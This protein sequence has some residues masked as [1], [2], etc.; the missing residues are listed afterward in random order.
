M[1][2]LYSSSIHFYK[3]PSWYFLEIECPFHSADD[4]LEFVYDIGSEHYSIIIPLQR[5]KT[6]KRICYISPWS[7]NHAFKFSDPAITFTRFKAVYLT[8]WFAYDRMLHRIS[9]YHPRFLYQ[10]KKEIKKIL[11]KDKPADRLYSQYLLACYNET[12]VH[13]SIEDGYRKSFVHESGTFIEN[14]ADLH[15]LIII[16]VDKR[17][18]WSDIKASIS[19]IPSKLPTVEVCLIVEDGVTFT[20]DGALES[21]LKVFNAKEAQNLEVIIRS[22][23]DTWVLLM[24]AGDLITYELLSACSIAVDAM[25]DMKLFYSDED[26][27]TSDDE[28]HRPS[29]K[30]DWSPDLLISKNY[31]SRSVIF[32]GDLFVDRCLLGELNNRHLNLLR[33][34]DSVVSDEIQHKASVYYHKKYEEAVDGRSVS[35][36]LDFLKARYPESGVNYLSENGVY[37]VKWVLPEPNPLVSLLIPTRDG[38][39]ILKP[40]VD[41]ILEL[42]TYSNFEILILNNQ[43]TCSRTLEYLRTIEKDD[44]VRVLEWDEPFNYSAINNFGALHAKGTIIG[45]VNNDIEPINPG[46]LDEMVSQVCRPEIGCVGAKLY[47]PNDTIQ[48]AGVILGIG[49]VA[50]HSH[51]F[52]SGKSDGY[53]GRLKAVQNYM[54]VTAA[55]LLVQ[56]TV[57]DQVGGLTEELA[58]AFNDVDFCLKVHKLGLRNLWTPFAELYHHESVSRGQD[59]TRLKRKRAYKEANYMQEAWGELL[60][61]DPFY[62]ENLTLIHEDFSLR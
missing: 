58:V 30:P 40:C 31:I 10:T 38:Y 60:F 53:E 3:V 2:S 23:R 36:V 50:G 61:H 62:N 25:P 57:F 32:R 29:F 17:V 43:S 39:D 20:Y 56:K 4:Y 45:L 41:A 14:P 46:W 49:G 7:R 54:A 24:Q 52:I 42:T 16:L 9:N 27:L 26:Y 15:F 35:L 22:Q 55:C 59:N 48:H 1:F 5:S 47:Y 13:R 19:S 21:E 12:F 44:R 8:P 6:I 51:R 18:S 11:K 28:L 37:H 33:F 34:T